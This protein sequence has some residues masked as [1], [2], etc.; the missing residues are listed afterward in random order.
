MLFCPA[1]NRKMLETAGLR[2]ADCV[3]FD[4][5]DSVVYSEKDNARDMLCQAIK[6]I[7]FGE[8]EVFARI[9]ALDTIFGE[10]DVSKLVKNGIKN[11]RLPMVENK[12]NVIELSQM[13]SFYEKEYDVADGTVSIQCSI[14]TPKGVLNAM[15]I[16][17]AS[18]R[19]IS[20]S[21]GTGDY[22]NCLCVNRTNNVEQFLYARSHIALCAS[23]AGIDAIDTVYFDV[24]DLDGFRKETEHV[25]M[26]GFNGK[27]CI[28]P[29]Q[30]KIVHDIFTPDKAEIN[31]A[32]KIVRKSQEA[33]DNGVGV[34]VIDDKMIDEPVIKKA[35]KILLLAEKAGVI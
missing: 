21:F 8:C 29:S 14:E 30:I 16:A 17:T 3:I 19:V 34:I 11:I 22:T 27:S 33:V 1:N 2:G 18:S 31:K 13:L 10:K 15:D 24:K 20:I 23:T 7:N 6:N 9:N 26:L 4:L 32:I 12:N 35:R 28:H 5:E 25:K